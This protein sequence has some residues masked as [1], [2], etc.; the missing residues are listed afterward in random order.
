M[1]KTLKGH[2]T[3][4]RITYF[5]VDIIESDKNELNRENYAVI[6]KRPSTNIEHFQKMYKRMPEEYSKCFED[7]SCEAY[8]DSWCEKHREKCLKNFDLNMQYMEK[9]SKEEF[10][11]TLDAFIKKH[12]KIEQI[13]DLNDCKGMSGIYIL[14]LDKYKQIYI[15]Q[16]TNIKNRILSHW[17]KTKPFDRLLFGQVNKS[18]LSI[19]VFGAFDTTRIYVYPTEDTYRVEAKLVR[20]MS[21]KYMLNRTAGGIGDN[22]EMVNLEIAAGAKHRNME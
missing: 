13:F 3:M 1:E 11:S 15:G 22:S 21:S 7:E 19:D 4:A 12:R 6:D 16:S 10:D 2:Y 8:T 5:G 14:V 18:I 9:I 17:N 20:E